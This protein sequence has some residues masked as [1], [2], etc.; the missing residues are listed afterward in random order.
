MY[1]KL[2]AHATG[3]RTLMLLLVL[4]FNV[5]DFIISSSFVVRFTLVLPVI[6]NCQILDPKYIILN[7]HTGAFHQREKSA[8]PSSTFPPNEHWCR[9]ALSVTLNF[10]SFSN[11]SVYNFFVERNNWL[12]CNRIKEKKVITV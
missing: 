6:V 1:P 8:F 2:I 10:D 11:V 12:G 3:D 7:F 5:D 4:T 9:N